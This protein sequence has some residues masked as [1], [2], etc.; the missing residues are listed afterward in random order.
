[1]PTRFGELG[2]DLYRA[3][4]E[5]DASAR[6]AALNTWVDKAVPAIS[7]AVESELRQLTSFILGAREPEWSL[8]DLRKFRRL[9]DE[10]PLMVDIKPRPVG[11]KEVV[12]T[13]R[14][15]SDSYRAETANKADRAIRQA[16]PSGAPPQSSSESSGDLGVTEDGSGAGTGHGGGRSPSDDRSDSMNPNNPAS[17]AAAD[18]HSN[19]MNPNNPAYH[20]SR[21]HR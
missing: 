19:Q 2:D 9:L 5:S 10:Y 15:A 18:N 12:T 21:G 20:S 17:Q 16:E 7:S 14:P 3:L 13:L 11:P 8:G 1:M 6:H 4:F